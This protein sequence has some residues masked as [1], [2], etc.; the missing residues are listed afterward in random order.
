[1]RREWT[2]VSIT[3]IVDPGVR[4]RG[5]HRL[6]GA[7]RYGLVIILAVLGGCD[8]KPAPKQQ[9]HLVL[10][11]G[12]S[13]LDSMLIARKPQAAAAEPGH[14]AARPERLDFRPTGAGGLA[15]GQVQLDND[16][17]PTVLKAVRVVGQTAAFSLG[18]DCQEGRELAK[19]AHCVIT[20]AFHPATV[21]PVEAAIVLDR[22]GDAP[23]L[24][25]PLAG[26]S[27][28]PPP[29][30]SSEASWAQTSILFAR[31]RQDA[32]LTIDGA[33]SGAGAQ[34][35]GRDDDYAEAGLPGLVSTFP[36]DRSRVITA[37]R[38]IPAVLENSIDSQLPGRAIAV[39]ESNV[40]G[41]DGRLVLIPAGSRVVGRYQSMGRAGQA[42]IDI[43]WSR[44]IRPDGASINIDFAAADVMGR[45]GIPGDLDS[46][47]FEKY[48]AS[49]LTSVVAAG[50]TW[51]LGGTTTTVAGA[52]GGV[53]ETMTPRA[54]AANRLGSDFDQ[55]AQ[56]MVQDNI[57]IRPVLIVAQ[58]TRLAIIPSED[59]WLRD[60]NRLQAATPP[61]N[62]PTQIKTDKF[63]E[64]LPGLVELIAENPTVEKAMPQTTQ[65]I[66][67]SALL[68]QLRA[69]AE[70]AAPAEAPT[71]AKPSAA[72]AKP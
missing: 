14:L 36:V 55:L 43:E 67:Q 45:A 17:G 31:D 68:Q 63:A 35:R 61:K 51:A 42:R 62:R 70:T 53:T 47:F 72:G 58:G 16:G 9:N 1:M 37:D 66:L 30:R 33:A 10:P 23:S 57:D 41:S 49:L 2:K 6:S 44:I 39:V 3:D 38:Y 20:V 7:L 24:L 69:S 32:G 40:Y 28:V 25:V 5:H 19:G 13:A 18:G 12:D 65:Q 64:L 34:H 59:I 46:R 21:G 50:G 4:R 60:P 8:D 48:G 26:E 15:V 22:Q 52:T 54:A 29:S 11:K 71:G 56:R 27:S